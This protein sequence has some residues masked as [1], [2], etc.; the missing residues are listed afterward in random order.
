MGHTFDPSPRLDHDPVTAPQTT[1]EGGG[2]VAALRSLMAKGL[3]TPAD[4][5]AVLDKFPQDRTAMITLLQQ[6]LGNSFVQQVL[7]A[8][9]AVA[10]PANAT[11]TAGAPA[12]T[13]FGVG[14]ALE[15]SMD[16][17]LANDN[18]PFAQTLVQGDRRDPRDGNFADDDGRTMSVSAT[19]ALTSPATNQQLVF[20]TQYE[21]L[22]QDGAQEDPLH[23]NRRADVLTNLLQYN[24]RFEV[25][26]GMH[27]YVGLGAGVQT[28]G[29]IGG[30]Q[31]QDWFHASGGMGGRRL[32]QGLQDNFGGAGSTT[33]P[34]VSGGFGISARTENDQGWFAEGSASL[35]GT[36]ALGS[37]G[38]SSAQ[39]NVGGSAGMR[40]VFSV[41]GAASLGLASPN[42]SNLRFAPVGEAM[43]GGQVRLQ[44]DALRKLGIAVSPYVML[45]SNSGGFADTQYTIGFVIGGGSAA[46]LT[47]PK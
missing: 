9:A 31:L 45:Q 24:Q 11:P 3:P 10:A 26:P 4:V 25:S 19:Q 7:K 37:Q 41:S 2:G 12:A 40:D 5:V 29:D 17:G 18:L 34:A 38:L 8:K 46:W 30:M 28:V 27:F 42:G 20:S 6:S 16:V 13:A 44:I 36:A 21:M 32:G 23:N 39:A 14:A 43:M 15:Y 22:T 47:P 1:V 35:T 33:M